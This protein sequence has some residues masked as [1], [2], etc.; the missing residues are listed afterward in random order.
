MILAGLLLYLSEEWAEEAL[1]R[2]E[3][4]DRVAKAAK[5]I[6]VSLLTLFEDGPDHAYEYL[7][8]HF[9]DGGLEEYKLGHDAGELE[10]RKPTFTVRGPY[11]NFADVQ[12]GLITERRALLSGKLH[13]SGSMFKAMKH[14][15]ALETIT[16][17]L[18]EIPCET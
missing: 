12:N 8:V 18:R 3:A 7:Y 2:V 17:S 14:M 16:G 9:R 13:L 15:R 10:G 6:D 1:R 4:D 5:G 11:E